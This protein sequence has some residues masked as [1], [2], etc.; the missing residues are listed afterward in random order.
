[1]NI[2]DD[3]LCDDGAWCNGAET[4]DEVSDCQAGTPPDCGDGVGCT[5]D[6]CNEGTDACD[7]AGDD[8]LC[9]DG[10]W[11]NGTETCDEVSDCQAG[12]P[13]DCDDGVGCTV[14]TCNEGTDACDNVGDDGLCDDGAWCNGAETCDEVNDCQAGTEVDCDDEIPCTE[15]YCNEENDQ[16]DVVDYC[17]GIHVDPGCP[18]NVM[19]EDEIVISIEI[20]DASEI[21]ALGLDLV[22]DPGVLA[23]TDFSTAGCLLEGWAEFNCVEDTGLISCD[24]VSDIPLPDESSGCLV[25]LDF[26]VLPGT[27][28]YLT[29]ISITEL[30]EDLSLMSTTPCSI[31]IGECME[32]WE[33]DDGLFCNGEEQCVDYFCEA[34]VEPCSPDGNDCTDDICIEEDDLCE[35]SCNATSYEDPCCEDPTCVDDTICIG[36]DCTDLD[37]DGYAIEG[38]ECGAVD[39]DDSDPGVN[40][41]MQGQDCSNA[42]DGIDNDCDGQIDEDNCGCFI[43]VVI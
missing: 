33:C 22:F 26:H 32:N 2:G 37:Q 9:D 35:Y 11:C 21:D 39:C 27:A 20:T 31:H 17:A 24:G 3:G 34:G 40:P 18:A 5:V 8:G 12:T 6:T 36:P 1:D 14:D 7:N 25:L 42:P 38:G 15:N 23:Y 16:C 28:G 4:C 10:A 19:P 41:G 29:Y 30:L 13:P 43:S